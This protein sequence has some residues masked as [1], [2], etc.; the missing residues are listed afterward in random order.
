MTVLKTIPRDIIKWDDDDRL[1]VTAY[2]KAMSEPIRNILGIARDTKTM[3][4]LE[5]DN[6][7]TGV[8]YMAP[9]QESGFE[10]CGARTPGC[11]SVCLYK[12]GHGFMESVQIAR[13][14]KT[15]WF[16]HRQQEFMSQLLTEI[17]ALYDKA[18]ENGHVPAV[19]L[20]G[21]SDIRWEDIKVGNILNI[22]Y[23]CEYVQF[24]DYTKHV[25]RIEDTRD[26]ENYHLTFSYAETTHN[27]L[28]AAKA[29]DLGANIAVV[30]DP[31]QGMPDTFGV[32]GKE[33]KVIDG[34]K[35][36]VR[37]WDTYGEPVVIGLIAKGRAI[38]DVDNAFINR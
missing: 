18:M 23:A 11:T 32:N 34:D 21:T 31:Y 30:F 19:R 33:L 29:V 27:Q 6:V 1:R 38:N 9:A 2:E 28:N 14:K 3:K 8:L 17:R 26:I 16:L 15:Y 13:L 37:F 12:S 10:M 36:D 7:L 20:N 4:S 24:Y 35:T 5:K 25:D 22:F